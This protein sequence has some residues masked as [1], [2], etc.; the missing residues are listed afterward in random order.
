[1]R[2]IKLFCGK[3]NP[4]L[5]TDSGHAHGPRNC[6]AYL[7]LEIRDRDGSPEVSICGHVWNGS[8]TDHIIGGQCVDTIADAFG[9][10]P[11]LARVVALW[12]RWHLNGMRAGSAVQEEWLRANPLD[13]TTYAYPKSHYEVASAALAAAGLNPD[14]TGYKY[15]SAWVREDVPAE[16]LTELRQLFGV[17]T[18]DT[19]PRGA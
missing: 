11:K 19:A 4:G 16:V 7:T 12:R 13:P 5:T 6:D 15:G 1:M 8:K 14:P 17:A 9:N 18:T 10:P 3:L 2:E